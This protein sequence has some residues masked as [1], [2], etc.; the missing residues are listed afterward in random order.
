MGGVQRSLKFVKYLPMF[1][2]QPIVF[3]TSDMA[4]YA[5]D[6]NLLDELPKETIIYRSNLL[7]PLAVAKCGIAQKKEIAPHSFQERGRG[8]GQKKGNA[9]SKLKNFSTYFSVLD[10]KIYWALGNLPKAIAICK[11][12]DISCIVSTSPPHSA[13][14]LA[15]LLS[16]ILNIPY[17]IDFRDDWV[18][19][20]LDQSPTPLH[21][22]AADS[23][24][25]L[26]L[27]NAKF[28]TATSRL[29]GESLAKREM[30]KSKKF[31]VKHK[32][33]YVTIT[34]GYDETDFAN[35]KNKST[36]KFTITYAGSFTPVHRPDAFL[37][38]L[39]ELLSEN[40]EWK[41]QITFHQA[42]NPKTLFSYLHQ[43]SFL[44]S[45]HLLLDQQS[46]VLHLFLFF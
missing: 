36:D 25:R 30:S 42:Q 5:Y 1:D 9:L 14:L 11:R 16:K 22:W 18:G 46:K 2:W 38:A 7:N 27:K 32:Q 45:F 43:P 12:H 21:D 41:N 31:H 13:H 3:T 35:F 15:L 4:Y 29:I 44:A 17:I 39:G 40:P 20:V 10:N 28:I 23:A 34:N 26:C 37:Q 8:R 33:K 6:E 19:G 24:L